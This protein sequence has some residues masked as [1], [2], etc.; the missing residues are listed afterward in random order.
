MVD[1]PKDLR[2]VSGDPS[3]AATQPRP[4]NVKKHPQQH[5]ISRRFKLI[6]QGMVAHNGDVDTA[7]ETPS[8]TIVRES[9][10]CQGDDTPPGQ[11]PVDSS[12]R[13]GSV[14]PMTSVAWRFGGSEEISS[15]INVGDAALVRLIALKSNA[16]AERE[17]F[18]HLCTATKSLAERLRDELVVDPPIGQPLLFGDE[19][20]DGAPTPTSFQEGR[21]TPSPA[22]GANPELAGTGVFEESNSDNV[23][24]AAKELLSLSSGNADLQSLVSEVL[25]VS[26]SCHYAQ[27]VNI[28]KVLRRYT[29]MLQASSENGIDLDVKVS[30]PEYGALRNEVSA[31]EKRE[32]EAKQLG[33][34]SYGATLR[35]ETISYLHKALQDIVASEKAIELPTTKIEEASIKA[36]GHIEMLRASAASS[37]SHAKKQSNV[38]AVK[39][40]EAQKQLSQTEVDID[41]RYHD[42]EKFLNENDQAIDLLGAELESVYAKLETAV[43]DRSSRLKHFIEGHGSSVIQHAAAFSRRELREGQRAKNEQMCAEHEATVAALSNLSRMAGSVDSIARQQHQELQVCVEGKK[44]QAAELSRQVYDDLRR[45]VTSWID[46]LSKN[47]VREGEKVAAIQAQV[48]EATDR[49]DQ[50]DKDLYTSKLA[51]VQSRREEIRSE[52]TSFEKMLSEATAALRS[53][54]GEISSVGE[55]EKTPEQSSFSPAGF[56][57]TPQP[58]SRPHSA[59]SRLPPSAAKTPRHHFDPSAQMVTL[60]PTHVYS[61]DGAMSTQLVLLDDAPD[62][63]QHSS[64]DIHGGLGSFAL[65]D[66]DIIQ[67]HQFVPLFNKSPIV[68]AKWIDALLTQDVETLKDVRDIHSTPSVWAQFL[69]DLPLLKAQLEMLLE[70]PERF[71]H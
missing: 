7:D 67:T 58:H 46:V 23:W 47:E 24:D 63:R 25:D 4:V 11:S 27:R 14:T 32:M 56:Q 60:T 20:S 2:N 64:D 62:S 52:I 21:A 16:A 71:I 18:Q 44:R 22:L 34:L 70:D 50:E 59:H 66:V 37:L 28:A 6:H 29:S 49:Y 35:K 43:H 8:C 15:I 55:G 53:V 65:V 5:I 69:P 19:D 57:V 40:N 61:E 51:E 1:S 26:G 38:L 17:A 68:T 36:K 30:L 9:Q 12:E 41:R 10:Q 3:D 54:V 33:N 31:M 45:S 48:R 42:L 13:R 39:S